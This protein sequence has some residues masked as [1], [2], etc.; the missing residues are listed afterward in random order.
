MAREAMQQSI[1]AFGLTRLT[2]AQSRVTLCSEATCLFG[3]ACF[4]ERQQRVDKQPI[5]DRQSMLR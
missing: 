3:F 5:D 1:Q 4:G 2:L